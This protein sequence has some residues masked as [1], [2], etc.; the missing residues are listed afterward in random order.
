VPVAQAFLCPVMQ[1]HRFTFNPFQ[2]NTYLISHSDGTCLIIDPGC[3][4]ASEQL[5]LVQFISNEHLKPLAIVNTH[6]HIDHVLGLDYLRKYYEIPFYLHPL[7]ADVLAWAPKS[8]HIWGFDMSEQDQPEYLLPDKGMLNIGNFALEIIFC[9]GHSP[10]SVCLL[11]SADSWLI[12]GDVLFKES[13]GR[14]DLPGGNHAQLMDSI[15]DKLFRLPESYTVYP[16]HGPETTL[17]HERLFN[18]FVGG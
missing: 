15:K 9:P 7:E 16:G 13:I 11:N 4:T 14:T 3:Y 5:Q 17:A 18:P 2:E 6:A 8:G 10:G 1:L 12:G